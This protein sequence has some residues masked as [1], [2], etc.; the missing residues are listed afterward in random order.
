MSTVH[1]KIFTKQPRE[2]GITV[3]N[4]VRPALLLAGLQTNCISK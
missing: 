2:Y 1:T 4:E 3:W